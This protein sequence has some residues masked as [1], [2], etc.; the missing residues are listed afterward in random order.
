MIKKIK[1][2]LRKDLPMPLIYLATAE[3]LA[4]WQVDQLNWSLQQGH[5]CCTI[6][7]FDT[8]PMGFP[9]E[10]AAAVVLGTVLEF[11]CSH[12]ETERLTILCGDEASFRAYSVL[13]DTK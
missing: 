11:L 6:S 3:D 1:I 10:Q 13:L 9:I 7:C 8:A 4:R 5:R 2:E 12:P